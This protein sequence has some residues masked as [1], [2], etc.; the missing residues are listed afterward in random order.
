M[1]KAMELKPVILLTDLH[2]L[3]ARKKLAYKKTLSLSRLK[4]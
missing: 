2:S 3:L 1:Q 4:A